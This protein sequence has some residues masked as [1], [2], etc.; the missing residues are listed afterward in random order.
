MSGLL[1]EISSVFWRIYGGVTTSYGNLCWPA[2]LE[3]VRLTLGENKHNI[4]W[5]LENA[6][7]IIL[8][9]KNSAET[10]IQET[11]PLE[12]ALERGAELV[13]I[14]P[15]RTETA[16]KASL[17]IQPRPGTDGALALGIARIMIESGKVDHSFISQYVLGYE[18]FR[19]S[20]KPYTGEFVEQI[21][22]VP[23]K[24]LHKLADLMVN[25]KPM[26][27][28]P[29]YGMQRYTNGGQ[30]IRCLLSLQIITGNIG[31]PGACFHY[32]NLQ[33]YVFDKVLE[34]LSYYPEIEDDGI[35]R[36]TVSKARLGHDMLAQ[37]DPELKMIWVERAFKI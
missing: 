23:E 6:R 19:E 5:D 21:T 22:G 17:L 12:K 25:T 30:T 20:L 35:T 4:P 31:K 27:I 3:A 32:A 18:T 11:I 15:R 37:K 7:L 26:T 16:E 1:N 13:V 29:G 28:I 14:D 9:G 34:P 2:G 8:W 10:N 36:R 33:S 24:Y